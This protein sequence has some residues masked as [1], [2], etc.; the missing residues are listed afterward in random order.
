MLAEDE[1]NWGGAFSKFLMSAEK[2]PVKLGLAEKQ[3]LTAQN[4]IDGIKYWAL[5]CNLCLMIKLH[6]HMVR[7][8]KK[9]NDSYGIG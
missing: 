3:K 1:F 4:P 2:F 5:D 7:R 8:S 6:E 9:S